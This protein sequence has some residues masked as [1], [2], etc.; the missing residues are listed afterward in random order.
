MISASGQV[1]VPVSFKKVIGKLFAKTTTAAASAGGAADVSANKGGGNGRKDG[2]N[3]KRAMTGPGQKDSALRTIARHKNVV[4]SLPT[5][6]L[7][8]DDLLIADL[9]NALFAVIG[10][11]NSKFAAM[12]DKLQMKVLKR[13]KPVARKYSV[14]L[15][16]GGI[17]VREIAAALD[18]DHVVAVRCS[19]QVALAMWPALAEKCHRK[20]SVRTDDPSLTASLKSPHV[21]QGS[22]VAMREAVCWCIGGFLDQRECQRAG[23]VIVG[24]A[25][26]RSEQGGGRDFFVSRPRAIFDDDERQQRLDHLFPSVKDRT[27]LQ[28]DEEAAYSVSNET[29]A[30]KVA[31]IAKK[32]AAHSGGRE[33]ADLVI[34]ATACVGGN[35]LAFAR[36]FR[37]VVAIEIDASKVE[38]LKENIAHV[39]SEEQRNAFVQHKLADDFRVVHGDC[40]CELPRALDAMHAGRA[41][42][43]VD[44]PWGGRHYASAAGGGNSAEAS[45]ASVHLKGSGNLAELVK[46]CAKHERVDV[47]LLKLPSHFDVPTF[48]SEM[49]LVKHHDVH[50]LSKQVTLLVLH[51][52]KQEHKQ[53]SL[54]APSSLP[55]PVNKR[56]HGD[57]DVAG[58]D[59]LLGLAVPTKQKKRRHRDT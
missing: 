34:D 3:E 17:D 28:I 55:L 42:V 46:I 9:G 18:K 12:K 35:A 25:K 26:I 52:S 54:S 41:V 48:L 59:S 43:F 38:F 21:A 20:I 16:E 58:S 33:A 8:G 30:A 57:G 44:P 6:R 4:I 27:K 56:Q 14:F 47:L 31:H 1:G 23:Q 40:L 11:E 50:L 53:K 32:L 29:S 13:K 49:E 10:G 19:R 37:Q 45:T 2:K 39:R 51:F 5:K 7:N 22:L 24:E 36:C 15:E